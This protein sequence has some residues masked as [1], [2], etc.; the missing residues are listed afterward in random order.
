MIFLFV[1]SLL[2]FGYLT[3]PWAIYAAVLCFAFVGEMYR[4][5]ASAMIADLVPPDQR[6][7]A[8]GLMYV[9]INVGCAVGPVIGGYLSH[10]SFRWLFLADAGTAIAYAVVIFVAARETLPS[11]RRRDE[12]GAPAAPAGPSA[13]LAQAAA[14]I[15]RDYR[16]LLFC[17]GILFMGTLMMQTM[18]T[19]PLHLTSL[20]LTT[21]DYGNIVAV[22]AV[23]V[24]LLQIPLNTLLSKFHRGHVLALGALL[25]GLGFG[26]IGL[27]RT[28]IEF[29]GAVVVFTMGE[30][31]QAPMVPAVTG[32]LAPAHMRGRYMGLVGVCFSGATALGVPL[33]GKVLEVYGP[34]VL[35][36]GCLGLGVVATILNL[37]ILKHLKKPDAA[38]C[39]ACGYSLAGV[40][41]GACP[42]CGAAMPSPA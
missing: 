9:A 13:T 1:I 37:S 41:P 29:V 21:V 24:V 15:A 22:N 17:L 7:F 2:V 19:F 5:A 39:G 28:P 20:G 32:D 12:S 33:G 18:S 40:T 23:M 16:F 8:Y 31:M 14:H 11:R 38:K 42:E 3:S 26:L 25:T 30:L 10:F 34:G 27:G 36:G 6:S 35:W 4:P